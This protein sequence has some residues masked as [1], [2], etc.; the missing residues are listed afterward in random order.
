MLTCAH[1][2]STDL[3]LYVNLFKLIFVQVLFINPLEMRELDDEFHI[4]TCDPNPAI[5]KEEP[6]FQ[7]FL[8]RMLLFLKC[9]PSITYI[10]ICLA[11]SDLQPHNSVLTRPKRVKF[12]VFK[13]VIYI[14]HHI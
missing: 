5:S 9:F 13:F 10:V 1:S 4:V 14:L 2:I 12:G 8:Q 3:F 11:C 6:F 7:D